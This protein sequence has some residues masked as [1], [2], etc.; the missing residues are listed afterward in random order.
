MRSAK[1][2][3]LLTSLSLVRNAARSAKAP[4]PPSHLEGEECLRALALVSV[5]GEV[6][7]ASANHTDGVECVSTRTVAEW[8]ARAPATRALLSLRP[9]GTVYGR[10]R[11]CGFT[12][13][14]D[15]KP[16]KILGSVDVC[17]HICV[18]LVL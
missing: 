12:T 13:H 3:L 7:C 18:A 6:E 9:V 4:S 11:V 14:Q 15:T 10:T 2:P 17:V 5:E 16:K 8:S 1:A